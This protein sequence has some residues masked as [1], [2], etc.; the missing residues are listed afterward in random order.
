MTLI[1]TP[2][3]VKEGSNM[4]TATNIFEGFELTEETIVEDENRV[5][6]LEESQVCFNLQVIVIFILIVNK[7]T[8]FCV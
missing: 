1:I 8:K 6:G 2:N 7:N 3:N 5:V 4:Y